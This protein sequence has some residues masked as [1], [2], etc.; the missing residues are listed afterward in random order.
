MGLRMMMGVVWREWRECE[1]LCRQGDGFCVD[2]A[3][4]SGRW[5]QEDN[6]GEGSYMPWLEIEMESVDEGGWCQKFCVGWREIGMR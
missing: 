2:M 4:A 5:V 1:G 3:S 6:E